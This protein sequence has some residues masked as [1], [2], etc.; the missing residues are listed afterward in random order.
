[1]DRVEPAGVALQIA[2]R[3]EQRLARTGVDRVAAAGPAFALEQPHGCE[4][5]VRSRW[6]P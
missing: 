3:F 2:R 5:S 4:S 1:M 6:S